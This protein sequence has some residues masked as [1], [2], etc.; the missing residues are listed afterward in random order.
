MCTIL[1]TLQSERKLYGPIDSYRAV[2]RCIQNYRRYTSKHSILD[3]L[4]N[5]PKVHLIVAS[6]AINIS[7]P[8]SII[9]VK[10]L[11]IMSSHKVGMPVLFG[12]SKKGKVHRWAYRS[13]W[14]SR[15]H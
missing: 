9:N 10:A 13:R 5:G 11:I 7:I 8:P 2:F 4:V 6:K 3:A 14:N 15:R 1:E 12:D